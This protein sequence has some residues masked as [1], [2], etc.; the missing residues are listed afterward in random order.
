MIKPAI[1]IKYNQLF[2]DGKFTDSISG[3]TLPTVDPRNEE[4]IT[5]VS[6]AQP[7]DIDVAVQSARRAFEGGAWSSR[8]GFHRS[9]VLRKWAELIERDIEYIANLETWDQG[10]PIK[11]VKDEIYGLLNF[12]TYFAGFADKI[13]GKTLPNN[14]VLGSFS[15]S[16]SLSIDPLL[17]IRAVLI[18]DCKSFG[19]I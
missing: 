14:D 9:K 19:A 11:D 10:K 3:R 13:Q 16:F 18:S 17:M 8:S 1:D 7:Q 6:D 2:I 12:I 4:I 15:L 5:N